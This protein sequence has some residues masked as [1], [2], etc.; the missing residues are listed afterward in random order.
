MQLKFPP[1]LQTVLVTTRA[2]L[3][4]MFAI[5]AAEAALI[6]NDVRLNGISF[7][8]AQWVTANINPH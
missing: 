5:P 3:G 4:A 2:C 1:I 8:N 6:I 7:R